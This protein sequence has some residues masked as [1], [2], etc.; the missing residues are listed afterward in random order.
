[1]KST[2]KNIFFN[3][4]DTI[5]ALLVALRHP[6]VS[7]WSKII[8]VFTIA[9]ALSPVDIIPDFIPFF[10]YLDD[11][12]ILPFLFFVAIKSIPQPIFEECKLKA[13]TTFKKSFGF[14]MLGLL[15]VLLTWVIIAGI[16][17]AFVA[18]ILRL[19]KL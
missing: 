2:F 17:Y 1:M 15:F 3:F 7:L 6:Q 5:G 4:R 14:V 16:I 9:Y 12:V 10:G 19:I 11:A 8:I 18:L 13:K